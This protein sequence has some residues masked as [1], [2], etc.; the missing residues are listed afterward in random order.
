MS[1]KVERRNAKSNSHLV[2]GDNR[3]GILTRRQIRDN[4]NEESESSRRQTPRQRLSRNENESLPQARKKRRMKQTTNQES[5]S[6][7]ISDLDIS[8][9]IKDVGGKKQL[10]ALL[11]AHKNTGRINENEEPDLE[12]HYDEES[13]HS[14]Q[15][16]QDEQ[17][18]RVENSSFHDEN[19]ENQTRSSLD[20]DGMINEYDEQEQVVQ[21]S[22]HNSGRFYDAPSPLIQDSSRYLSNEISQSLVYHQ[23]HENNDPIQ[24]TSNSQHQETRQNDDYYTPSSEPYNSN[25]SERQSVARQIVL[26]YKD[27]QFERYARAASKWIYMHDGFPDEDSAYDGSLSALKEIN[28]I[29]VSDMND[30]YVPDQT[31]VKN[32]LSLVR[33]RRGTCHKQ[34]ETWIRKYAFPVDSFESLPSD[35][36][37]DIRN[38]YKYLLENMRFGRENYEK[39]G[40]LLLNNCLVDCLKYVMLNNTSSSSRL[41]RIESVTRPLIAIIFSMIYYHLA[42]L[43]NHPSY[44]EA[45]VKDFTEGS[46]WYNIYKGLM[47]PNT[48]L[49]REIYWN[50]TI[51]FF[52]N[53]CID[54]DQSD[55]NAS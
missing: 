37:K 41:G 35:A 18:D 32:F 21:P 1:K 20:N 50:Q 15:D 43:S 40:R 27:T 8:E 16:E 17:G 29:S 23:F 46:P 24:Q 44:T 10:L 54:D 5:S 36:A 19:H 26:R 2:L 38:V 33:K 7:D 53:K 49:G 14:S 31:I 34:V 47:N 55:G 6:S 9:F 42:K 12:S 11:S 4:E 45:K 48:L 13:V 30:I 28:N 3:G 51:V 39:D 22:F 52:N 25:S